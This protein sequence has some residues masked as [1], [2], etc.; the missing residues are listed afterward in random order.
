MGE[1]GRND[2]DAT[3]SGLEHHLCELDGWEESWTCESIGDDALY[4]D[5][6]VF[7]TP[8]LQEQI[9]AGSAGVLSAR[10]EGFT[11]K[12]DSGLTQEDRM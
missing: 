10:P 6:L 5:V 11:D 9:L 3:V 1:H 4:V 2:S 7:R 12:T 8:K